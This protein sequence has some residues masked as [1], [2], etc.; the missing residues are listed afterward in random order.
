VSQWENK[1]RLNAETRYRNRK[2]LLVFGELISEGSGAVILPS[3]SERQTGCNFADL[4]RFPLSAFNPHE[5][6]LCHSPQCRCAP[7]MRNLPRNSTVDTQQNQAEYR[8]QSGVPHP[9][10]GHTNTPCLHGDLLNTYD[11]SHIRINHKCFA[12]ILIFNL[13]KPSDNFTYQQV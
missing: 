1:G 10:T 11:P 12:C 4:H 9:G 3:S 13:L 7:S 2:Q 5:Q 8:I 6:R